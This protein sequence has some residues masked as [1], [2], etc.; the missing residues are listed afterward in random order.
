MG[1]VV[2]RLPWLIGDD[3]SSKQNKGLLFPALKHVIFVVFVSLCLLE[4]YYF[5]HL[6]QFSMRLIPASRDRRGL[7]TVASCQSTRTWWSTSGSLGT[8]QRCWWAGTCRC[9]SRGSGWSSPGMETHSL[10]KQWT[11]PFF[12]WKLVLLLQ[13]LHKCFKLISSLIIVY[14][15]ILVREFIRISLILVQLTFKTKENHQT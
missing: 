13:Q 2:T 10:R 1:R 14:I 12:G 7:Y 4:S 15:I 3:R 11:H 6:N 8:L 9:R 5:P